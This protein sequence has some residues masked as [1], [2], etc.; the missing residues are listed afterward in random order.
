MKEISQ[1]LICELTGGHVTPFRTHKDL[2]GT[3]APAQTLIWHL[4]SVNQGGSFGG[5]CMGDEIK[6]I[7]KW[8]GFFVLKKDPGGATWNFWWRCAARFSKTWPH[9]RAKY[10][11]FQHSF[12]DWLQ[13]QASRGPHKL[14]DILSIVSYSNNRLIGYTA[15]RNFFFIWSLAS[16]ICIIFRPGSWNP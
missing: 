4:S 6:F 12:L 2:V 3:N 10:V 13:R 11:I 1:R 8:K 5:G 16:K 9:F 15:G 7:C 14:K